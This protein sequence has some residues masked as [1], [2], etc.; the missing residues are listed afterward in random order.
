MGS[1]R[2]DSLERLQDTGLLD[3]Q[4][5]SV[6]T[7]VEPVSRQVTR[8]TTSREVRGNPW[9]EEMLEGSQLG[10]IRRKKGGHISADGS[11]TYEWEV[12]EIEG[13]DMESSGAAKRKLED[14]GDGEDDTEMRV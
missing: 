10:K 12:V 6:R 2:S 1:L 8:E 13:G 9:F 3:G 5:E 4:E 7:D 11:T 14:V